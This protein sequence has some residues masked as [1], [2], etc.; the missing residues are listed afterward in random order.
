LS[1][2]DLADVIAKYE[3]GATTSELGAM[4]RVSKSRISAVLRQHGVNL[5]R[6]GLTNE[7]ARE[8]GD[9]YNTGRSL[10]WLG[11]RYGISNTTASR[12]LRKQCIEVRPRPGWR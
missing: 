9:F 3:S 6:Q 1:A 11:A 12:I 8:A 2:E 7:Q 4:Y 10:A 5:R